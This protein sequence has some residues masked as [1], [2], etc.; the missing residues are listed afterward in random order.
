MFWGRCANRIPNFSPPCATGSWSRLRSCGSVS[1]ACSGRS[2]SERNG[3]NHSKTMEPFCGVHFSNELIDAMPVHLIVA[4]GRGGA[5]ARATGRTRPRADLLLSIVQSPMRACALHL[6]KIP[7]AP[8]RRVRD[9]DQPGGARLDRG[10]RRQVAT[11]RGADRGL[12]V[13]AGMNSTLQPP[14]RD[15]AMLRQP[16]RPALAFGKGGA[17][18]PDGARRMDQPG[19]AGGEMRLNVSRASPISIIS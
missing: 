8:R 13:A 15:S 18:R 3:R 1:R 14:E 11:R 7:P 4:D 2:G 19:R 16:P 9:G 5:L 10:A 6:T 17:K 12:R